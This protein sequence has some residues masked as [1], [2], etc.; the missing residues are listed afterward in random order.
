MDSTGVKKNICHREAMAKLTEPCIHI[1]YKNQRVIVK[2]KLLFQSAAQQQL[3]EIY[4]LTNKRNRLQIKRS[5]LNHLTPL[6]L[7]I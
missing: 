4:S 3:T 5:W 2:K 1:K 7:A 6:S